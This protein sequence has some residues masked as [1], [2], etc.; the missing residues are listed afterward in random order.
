[1]NIG[2]LRACVEHVR[3]C[4]FAFFY[5]FE[6]TASRAT[7]LIAGVAIIDISKCFPK[8]EFQSVDSTYT[9]TIDL[10]MGRWS[11]LMY[12]HAHSEHS[13]RRTTVHACT[14]KSF[15]ISA[16]TLC[17][18]SNI[19]SWSNLSARIRKVC[20]STCTSIW[21][22]VFEMKRTTSNKI[23]S[24]KGAQLSI[25]HH[26]FANGSDNSGSKGSSY[27]NYSS[28]WLRNKWNEKRRDCKVVQ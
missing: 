7:W 6:I 25:V 5:V 2:R 13:E 15:C 11:R 24:I 3:I 4:T 16:V 10:K 23:V 8:C 22:S 26:W 9:E 28:K 21:I 17:F 14:L 27:H 20:G 19:F 1:M 12:V 18:C